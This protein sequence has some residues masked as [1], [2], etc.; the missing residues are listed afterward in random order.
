[1]R[2]TK[3]NYDIPK[4]G[5]KFTKI[6]QGITYEMTVIVVNNEIYY[7]VNDEVFRSPTGA[8]KSITKRSV[9]GWKFWRIVRQI[10][11]KYQNAVM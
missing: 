8:A 6:W 2:G 10:D 1:M 7:K 4:V 5:S 3:N 11:F 9:N